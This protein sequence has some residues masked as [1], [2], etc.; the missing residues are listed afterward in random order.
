MDASSFLGEGQSEH[1]HAWARTALEDAIIRGVLFV[2]IFTK[3]LTQMHRDALSPNPAAVSAI[4]TYWPW[5]PAG[6]QVC[7]TC[8]GD[9][10]RPR[11]LD[12]LA[13][14]RWPRWAPSHSRCSSCPELKSFLAIPFGLRLI[15]SLVRHGPIGQIFYKKAE[16]LD[17]QARLRA[18]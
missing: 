2:P 12:S 14:S 17:R 7:C 3:F 13:P 5:A 1:G 16:N 15:L 4:G 18:F 10:A 8:C 9:G 6:L 11:S